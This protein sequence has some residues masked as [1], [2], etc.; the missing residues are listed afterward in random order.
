MDHAANAGA[1][2]KRPKTD[3]THFHSPITAGWS[4]PDKAGGDGV[5]HLGVWER[6][7][8]GESSA[9][10]ACNWSGR[11]R[12][13]LDGG[14]SG[15]IDGQMRV[16][17]YKFDDLLDFGMIVMDCWVIGTHIGL[18]SLILREV[19]DCIVEIGIE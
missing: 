10:V 19:A 6:R 11:A 8:G 12:V 15:I 9:G 14:G 1:G 17:E 13:F 18:F 3:S 5:L 16:G 7:G 4:P 2:P